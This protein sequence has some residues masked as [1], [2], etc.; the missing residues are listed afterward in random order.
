MARGDPEFNIQLVLS[1]V[2]IFLG[3]V[4]AVAARGGDQRP[5]CSAQR[6]IYRRLPPI[7]HGALIQ[8]WLE[9][10][11]ASATLGQLQTSIGQ[12]SGVLCDGPSE[13]RDIST[14]L[15]EC[16]SSIGDT[17]PVLGQCWTSFSCLSRRLN[18][19]VSPSC[20]CFLLKCFVCVLLFTVLDHNRHVKHKD[21]RCP[22]SHASPAAPEVADRVCEFGSSEL[23]PNECRIQLCCT[24][25][26]DDMHTKH[27]N[28]L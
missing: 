13:T 10:G 27:L 26:L 8:C 21:K 17:G 14:R 28:S 20:V 16:W 3:D 6:N 2:S 15:D 1:H 4:S 24:I 9:V 23:F 22:S 25:P 19:V 12:S 11:P 7:R 18:S 5:R